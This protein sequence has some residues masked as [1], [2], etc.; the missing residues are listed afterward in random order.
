[1]LKLTFDPE[2]P[3]IR[4]LSKLADF[5]VLSVLWIICCLPAVTI[6]PASAA[7]YYCAVKSIRKERGHLIASFFHSFKEN[8]PTGVIATVISLVLAVPLAYGYAYLSRLALADMGDGLVLFIGYLVLLTL[9]LGALAYMFP[10]LSR[11]E[12]KAGGLMVS[13]FT[14]AVRHLPTTLCVLGITAA[15]SSRRS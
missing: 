2:S 4:M 13:S 7:L 6:G 12:A 15:L 10:L 5:A 11:F 9:P 14:L 8:L 1:M 3:V